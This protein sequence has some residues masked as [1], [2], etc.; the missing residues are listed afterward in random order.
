MF[1][2]Y[3]EK[4]LT[5]GTKYPEGVPCSLSTASLRRRPLG[6]LSCFHILHFSLSYHAIRS[7]SLLLSQFLI[8][9]ILPLVRVVAMLTGLSVIA[10]FNFPHLKHFKL[11]LQLDNLYYYG[12][13]G[14]LQ[15][16]KKIFLISLGICRRSTIPKYRYLSPPQ[17]HALVFM[18]AVFVGLC[19]KSKY[20]NQPNN[21]ATYGI[22]VQIRF[23]TWNVYV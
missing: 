23:G 22:T 2:T 7:T 4:L 18:E 14:R 11:Y 8:I 17:L 21:M 9:G 6:A 13:E 12:A 20:Q 19:T 1:S 10:I 15:I 16:C 5:A 3:N